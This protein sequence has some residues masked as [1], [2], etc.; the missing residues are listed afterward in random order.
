[1]PKLTN[2]ADIAAFYAANPKAIPFNSGRTMAWAEGNPNAGQVV[3]Y[4]TVWAT[5]ADNTLYMAL[6]TDN[7]FGV[8]RVS[9]NAFLGTLPGSDANPIGA[10]LNPRWARDGKPLDVIWCGNSW[11]KVMRQQWDK[12]ST[13]AVICEAPTGKLFFDN[14]QEGDVSEQYMAVKISTGYV[15]GFYQNVEVGVV[16]YVNKRLLPGM[17]KA[18]NPNA[19]D[20][21]PDG[22]W[23]VWKDHEGQAVNEPNR[24]YL[25]SD[26]AKG[27]VKPVPVDSDITNGVKS[28]GHAGY[29]KTAAGAMVLVYQDNRT[30]WFKWFDPVT[31][32]ST[33][34]IEHAKLGYCGQHIARGAPQGYFLISTYDIL[35]MTPPAPPAQIALIELATGKMIKQA[36][37]QI[38]RGDYWTEGPAAIST[39]LKTIYWGANADGGDNLEIYSA[40]VILGA[41]EPTPAPAPI[42][43]PTP[44]PVPTPPATETALYHIKGTYGTLP[45]NFEVF[46]GPAPK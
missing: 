44:E 32:K 10:G 42:P 3:I 31:G 11:N 12:P 4:S 17:V 22:K 35:P 6:R 23:L 18:G 7:T 33:R 13:Q 16:D 45:I 14:G 37:P 24:F 9:D 8:H 21:S 28:V 34:I 38:K 27:V 20:I 39:D 43:E 30:D 25:I 1:M 41:P 36:D 26:L 19:V 40:P 15:G 2:I 29:A 5:N 46:S